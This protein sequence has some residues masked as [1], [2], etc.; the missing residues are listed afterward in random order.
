M[1]KTEQTSL[2]KTVTEDFIENIIN[3]IKATTIKKSPDES[4]LIESYADDVCELIPSYLRCHLTGKL[5]KDPVMLDSGNTYERSA[6]LDYLILNGFFD[7]KTS[8][9]LSSSKL[10]PNNNI[11]DAI[12]EFVAL[13]MN[14]RMQQN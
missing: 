12:Q 1:F 3:E 11:K 8:K 6:V 2:N 4:K 7:P 13:N 9:K 14:S 10:V 5:M